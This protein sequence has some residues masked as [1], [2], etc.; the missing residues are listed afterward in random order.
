M[1]P[2]KIIERN[3]CTF[4]CLLYFSVKNWDC[5]PVSNVNVPFFFVAGVSCPEKAFHPEHFPFHLCTSSG[6]QSK[7]FK[8]LLVK[9]VIFFSYMFFTNYTVTFLHS[10]VQDAASIRKRSL[11]SDLSFTRQVSN[12]NSSIQG[13]QLF[14]AEFVSPSDHAQKYKIYQC[15]LRLW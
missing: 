8:A 14:W 2:L 9:C 10:L 7:Y 11:P 3:K 12:I 5:R 4:S 13:C 6:L 1:T 15:G